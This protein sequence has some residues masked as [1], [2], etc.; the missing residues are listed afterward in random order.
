MKYSA[1]L[2]SF[3]DADHETV[4]FVHDHAS[5]SPALES[6]VLGDFA[7]SEEKTENVKDKEKQ[8]VV[9]GEL[10]SSDKMVKEFFFDEEKE[11]V[12]EQMILIV[13]KMSDV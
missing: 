3:H 8:S 4:K 9:K 5:L 11:N 10:L 13:R 1:Y 7:F 2:P 6:D 12:F